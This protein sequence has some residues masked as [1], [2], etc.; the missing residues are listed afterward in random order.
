MSVQNSNL[1]HRAGIAVAHPLSSALGYWRSTPLWSLFLFVAI[2]LHTVRA[3]AQDT[4]TNIYPSIPPSQALVT[5]QPSAPVVLTNQPPAP[6]TVLTNQPLTLAPLPTNQQLAPPGPL[7][8]GGIPGVPPGPRFGGTSQLASAPPIAS[9]GLP[10]GTPGLLQWG[11]IHLYPHFLYQ[12]SYGNSLEPFPGQ[13]VN[14][15][16]NQFS[17]GILIQIGSHWTLDYTPTLRYYSD[18]HLQDGTDQAVTLTGATTYDD[19]TFGLSQSY[20]SSSQPLI[21]TAAQLSQETYSTS[22]TASRQLGS[23]LSF[24]LSLSQYFLY[25]DQPIAFEALTDYRTWSTMDWLNYQFWPKFSVGIGAGFT[26]NN[27]SVGPDMTSEQY[28]GRIIW[29]AGNKL[30]LVFSGGLNDMQFV[31]VNTPDLL[32]PIFSFS[33]QYQLFEPTTLAVGASSAVSPAY[34]QDQVSEST[35]LNAGITQRLLGR[36][37][38][39]VSGAYSTSTYQSST[40]GPA[41]ANASNFDSTSFNVALSTT[42]L[43]RAT[44]SIFYSVDYISSGSAFYNYTIT[45]TGLTVGYRF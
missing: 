43:K 7:P 2:I 4:S 42:F 9:A 36:L 15:F 8:A 6:I 34:F 44:A 14:S 11:P 45:Q 1:T 27:L 16:I 25:I 30:S 28:Q 33:A 29:S 10:A 32:S 13:Q 19:W 40:I 37:Y 24:D 26:Y 23:K 31:G 12:L 39:N 18:P 5:N 3:G 17:P 41:Q 38:L 22:L 35:G 21:E 20:V